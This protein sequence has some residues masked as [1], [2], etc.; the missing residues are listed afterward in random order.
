M[1]SAS[2]AVVMSTFNEERYVDK[3]LDAVEA[4]TTPARIVAIDG[5]SSDATVELLHARAARNS[6]LEVRAD[7]VRRSLPEALNLA[8]EHVTEDFVAKIDARTFPA[9]DFLEQALRVFAQQDARVAC[10]GGRPEQY[11]ESP[12]GNGV[13]RARMSRFGVGGSGYADRRAF[14]DVD[15]VQCGV[16]RRSALM[17]IGG[18]DPGLQ[19]GEDEELNWRLR[20]AGYRILMDSRIRFRYVTRNTWFSAF[21]QYRNYGRARARVVEKHPDF[22]R[23]R[24]LV[25]SAALV[26]GAGLVC[27][28]PVSKTAL[29]AAS[30][31][32]GVYVVGALLAATAA[33][34]DNP[35]EIP[36]TASAFA[37]LHMGYALGL[38]EGCIKPA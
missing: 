38:L 9:C 26:V 3:A 10:V 32:A 5:G 33:S 6:M 37:A 24:H 12:F 20:E 17:E 28:S 19:F 36:Y 18:F 30:T 16:Y 21:K 8:L 11:G 25:P 27:A 34:R 13:A 35:Q 15:T 31:L 14:A 4:Q 1:G 29:R 2:V 23:T 22:I 7:G